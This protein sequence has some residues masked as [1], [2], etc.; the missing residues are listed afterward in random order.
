MDSVT[1][2]I[3][4]QPSS[5]DEGCFDFADFEGDGTQLISE[6]VQGSCVQAFWSVNPSA[7]QSVPSP[8]GGKDDKSS[9]YIW[10]SLCSSPFAS[11]EGQ[12]IF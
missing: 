10:F 11:S 5:D 4:A 6:Y 9:V 2:T 3:T 12:H 8:E 7:D 1:M